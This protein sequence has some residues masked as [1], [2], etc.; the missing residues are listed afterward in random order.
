PGSPA[1][2]YRYSLTVNSP[3]GSRTIDSVDGMTPPELYQVYDAIRS[4]GTGS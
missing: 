4:L 3:N 2:A 1:D